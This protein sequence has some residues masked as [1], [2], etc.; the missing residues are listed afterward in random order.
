MR[1][2]PPPLP[3]WWSSH[4]S[5]ATL[6]KLQ[7]HGLAAAKHRVDGNLCW[8][9]GKQGE[10]CHLS[11]VQGS[12]LLSEICHDVR[13]EGLNPILAPAAAGIQVDKDEQGCYSQ[14][15]EVFVLIFHPLALG[16]FVWWH[17]EVARG[18]SAGG[19]DVWGEQSSQAGTG[20]AESQHSCRKG[21]R[22]NH[23]MGKAQ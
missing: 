2:K 14:P 5:T 18:V 8:E 11:W 4:C 12:S 15:K 20:T 13:T 3:C 19:W 10:I 21:W 16:G 17:W 1:G 7:I 6:E 23:S 22:G 9:V